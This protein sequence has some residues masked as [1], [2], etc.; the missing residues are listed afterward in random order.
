MGLGIAWPRPPQLAGDDVLGHVAG[1]VARVAAHAAVHAVGDAK[2]G[3]LHEVLVVADG[4]EPERVAVGPVALGN[5]AQVSSELMKQTV[6]IVDLGDQTSEIAILTSGI[7]SFARTLSVG[8]AG[9]PGNGQQIV[10]ALKQSLVAWSG[11]SEHPVETIV[12]CGAGSELYGMEAYLAAHVGVEVIQLPLLQIDEL[13]EQYK[14]LLNRYAKAIAV[15]L[16]GWVSTNYAV[17]ACSGFPACNGQWWPVMDF[18]RGFAAECGQ[19]G[20]TVVGGDLT[21]A[22]QVVVAT[23]PFQLPL[24]A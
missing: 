16:G 21:R 6:A 8:V 2:G 5:L 23:G 13:S 14:P 11:V 20:A 24:P 7:T 15:A 22:D 17:L 12:L 9:L 10:S 1:D 4:H 19:V 3:R 18:A